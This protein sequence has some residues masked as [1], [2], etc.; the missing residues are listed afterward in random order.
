MTLTIRSKLS[1]AIM[2]QA[3]F[4]VLI[5]FCLFFL[6]HSFERIRQAKI[7]N[8]E[9]INSIKVF[10]L[11]IKDYSNK[12]KSYEQLKTVRNDT[13]TA[14]AGTALAD[15]IDKIWALLDKI[16]NY[17][18]QNTS[19]EE[20]LLSL[21]DNCIEQSS[22]YINKLSQQLADEKAREKVSTLER[23][24]IAGANSN[25]EF[26]GKIKILFLKLKEDLAREQELAE[27]LKAGIEN[28][29]TDGKRLA[30]TPYA[31]LPQNS[32][33]TGQKIQVLTAD[34]VTNVKTINTLGEEI[35]SATEVLSLALNEHDIESTND[36]FNSIS[37]IFK[38]VF[39]VFLVIS[40]ILG[41]V[42]FN[43]SRLIK[44]FIDDFS[45]R[46]ADLSAGILSV[47]AGN[48][49]TGR[50]DELGQL[51]NVL[52]EMRTRLRD[53]VAQVQSAS[54]N[55]ASGSEEMSSS[56]EELSQGST[57]QAS[58]LEEITSSMEE[59]GSN[60]NQNADNAAETEK[61]SRQA[62]IDA[63]DGGR[64][65]QN[66]VKAMKNIAEKISI[67]EEIA[68]QTNLLALNAA[69]EAARAGDAGRGFAVVAAEVRKLAERSGLA[70]KEIGE[71][72]SSSVDVAEKAGRMLEK[73]VP[74]IRKTAELV[75]EISAASKEQTAGAD[76]INQAIAQLD[77]VVQQNASSAEEVSSTAQE[78]ASQA[79]QLQSAISF[80]TVDGDEKQSSGQRSASIR[81]Q[82]DR[83]KTKE[84]PNRLGRPSHR[85]AVHENGRDNGA[86]RLLPD[87]GQGD[88]ADH[89]FERF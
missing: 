2:I 65:V 5:V 56:S 27:L 63:E 3:L 66:T 46:I 24:V 71:L 44:N 29:I 22:T 61:I 73:M 55:V 51:Y 69:I 32:L 30:D 50:K 26:Y 67:I 14:I 81:R 33:D 35:D 15:E 57:E 83:L 20:R 40:I 38:T 76:Q 70:A 49:F 25:S 21:S 54:D 9:Q 88:A 17:R 68:R 31:Y 80:F 4:I 59:M 53:I 74:D 18:V 86:A 43:L 36:S 28:A 89:D 62:A 34:Y 37:K 64:Q 8:T 12:S 60:I 39:I 47:R 77:Q 7:Q 19:I 75:Q 58:N 23:L 16:E 13:K 42:N 45:A 84:A 6:N 1:I 72:S 87:M 79:Q 85:P 11:S 48:N 78:L 41:F 82:Q 52:E 10:A